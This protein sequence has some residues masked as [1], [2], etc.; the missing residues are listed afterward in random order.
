MSEY[1]PTLKLF[2]FVGL[3][4]PNELNNTNALTVPEVNKII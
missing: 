2:E 1:M 3:A 4:T